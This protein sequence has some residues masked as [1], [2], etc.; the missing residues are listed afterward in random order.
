M[1]GKNQHLG[2]QLPV[3][4]LTVRFAA[5][6]QYV[7]TQTQ[8]KNNKNYAHESKIKWNDKNRKMT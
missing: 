8:N 5:H 6:E 4:Q 2:N 1:R 7:K 3:C